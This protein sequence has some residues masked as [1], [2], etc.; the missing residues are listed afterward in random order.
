MDIMTVAA[1]AKQISVLKD[2]HISSYDFLLAATDRDE[3]NIVIASFA[4]KLGCSKVIAR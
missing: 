3:K 1:N 4:K 2:L